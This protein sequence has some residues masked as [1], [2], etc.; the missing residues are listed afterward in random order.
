MQTRSDLTSSLAVLLAAALWATTGIFVKLIATASDISALTL[1]FWRDL[2]T[3]LILLAVIG[4]ARPGWLRVRWRDLGWLAAQGASLGIFHMLWFLSVLLNGAAVATVQ[5]AAM[6]AIVAVVAW[7]VWRESLTW[8][9]VLAIVLTFV[10]TVL[11]SGLGLSGKP[12]LSVGGLVLGLGIPLTYATW[13]LV[14]KKVRRRYNPF[15]MLAY[16]FAFAALVELPFQF[17]TP[18]PWPVA[19]LA[20]LWF[21]GLI[22][23]STLIP[24]SVYTSALG[25]LPASVATILAMSEIA[26]V[27]VYAYLLLD[28]RLSASQVLGSLL[29]VGGVL[30]LSGYRWRTRAR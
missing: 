6:P 15:T 25:R 26:F 2:T 5:Q 23:L 27:A 3:C 1:A 17:L 18:W 13:N 16:V 19:P 14:G 12:G 28:E 21:G 9:K 30:M 4:L 20:L 24:F 8:S 29:V 22:V 11:V 7:L 10:G